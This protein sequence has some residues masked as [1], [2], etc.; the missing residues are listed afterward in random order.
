MNKNVKFELSISNTHKNKTLSYI[1]PCMKEWKG[2]NFFTN[3]VNVA[4]VAI[5]DCIHDP[6]FEENDYLYIVVNIS[7]RSNIR[8]NTV[9]NSDYDFRNFLMILDEVRSREW[10]V[11]DYPLMYEHSIDQYHVV[12]GRLPEHLNGIKYKFL[13]GK[14][15][16]LYEK[17]DIVKY[18]RKTYSKEGVDHYTVPF[19]VLTKNEMYRQS[20]AK[21][22]KNDYGTDVDVD[23]TFELDYPPVRQN[24][25][26]NYD[27]LQTINSK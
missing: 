24:E 14:Y 20:F 17:S 2:F 27:Y 10:F 26:L 23:E 4:G 11:E 5:G 21:K 18:I 1:Y 16:E 6:D 12:V 15:S 9:V 19:L 7:N 3:Q 22:L 13:K 8:Y 25:V